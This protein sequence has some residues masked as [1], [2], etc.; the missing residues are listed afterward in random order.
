MDGA[1]MLVDADAAWNGW[2]LDFG[3]SIR[4]LYGCAPE[5]PS[6]R[7]GYVLWDDQVDGKSNNGML[8]FLWIYAES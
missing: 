4:V 7:G 1:K 2:S 6:R 5:S 3:C 8:V